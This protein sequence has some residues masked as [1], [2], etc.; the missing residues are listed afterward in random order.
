M[1]ELTQDQRAGQAESRAFAA[2]HIAPHADAFDRQEAITRDVVG[3]LAEAGYLGSHIPA[4]YSGSGYD[5]IKCGLLHEEIGRA[6]S[7]VRTLLT[8]HGMVSHAILRLGGEKQR[9]EWLP[10]LATGE[11]LAAFAL[12]EPDA[13]SDAA[14]IHSV[15]TDAGD[16]YLLTGRKKWISFGQL[17]DLFL[18]IA[19]L[20]ADGQIG[21]FLVPSD[22]PGLAVTPMS[23]LLGLRASMLAELE[24]SGCKVPKDARV[25]PARMASGLVSTAALHFGRYTVAWGCVGIGEACVEASFRHA[26]DRKQFGV[27]LEKHQLVRRMLTDMMTDVRAARGLCLQAGDSWQTNSPAAIHETLIAKYFASCMVTRVAS[28]AVQVHGA[29]GCINSGPVERYFR[30]ARIMEIIEGSTEIQQVTIAGYG[31]K[32]YAPPVATDGNG[33]SGESG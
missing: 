7:S 6:C 10:K 17:A 33:G 12:S 27:P 9:T 32:L 18:V 23:G 5:M 20:G 31:R 21:G 4:E 1:S 26:A 24:L 22:T 29:S 16:H 15:A 28:N 25:G 8:V 19:R 3:S 13:G 2:K 14:G 11:V 30:D